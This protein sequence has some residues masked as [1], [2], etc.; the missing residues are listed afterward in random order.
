MQLATLGQSGSKGTAELGNGRG[1]DTQASH[2]GLEIV[3]GS[4]NLAAGRVFQADSSCMEGHKSALGRAW[5]QD[6]ILGQ[7]E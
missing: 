1:A 2:T 3:F 6:S 4:G 5:E 7:M